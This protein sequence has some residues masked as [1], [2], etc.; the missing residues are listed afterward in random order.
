MIHLA[1]VLAL[2]ATP[3]AA[4]QCAPYADMVAQLEASHAE[5]PVGGGITADGK[6]MAI[7]ARAVAR[8][9]TLCVS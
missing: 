3:A 1:A 6:M 5:V 8:Q 2:I 9:E 4:L 7:T